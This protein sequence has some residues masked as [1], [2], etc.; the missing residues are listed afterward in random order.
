M[1]QKMLSYLVLIHIPY[2]MYITWPRSILTDTVVVDFFPRSI[3]ERSIKDGISTLL[4]NS[5]TTTP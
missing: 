2:I 1:M 3:N 5:G 4:K